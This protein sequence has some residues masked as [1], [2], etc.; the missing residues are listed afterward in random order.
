VKEVKVRP[1][2]LVKKGDVLLTLDSRQA[3]AALRV[4]QIRADS[5][6]RERRVKMEQVDKAV[7]TL[8]DYKAKAE[9]GLIPMSEYAEIL[10]A[11]RRDANS[12]E[13]AVAQAE[14]EQA[15]TALA[16]YQVVAPVDGKIKLANPNP[17]E[18]VSPQSPV[19]IL[20]ATSPAEI[21]VIPSDPPKEKRR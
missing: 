1:G 21:E 5:L 18:Y 19:I 17:G 12:T 16:Q 15:I 7:G 2:T 11:A 8:A 6:E 10:H 4:A 3:E 20:L 9:N 13:H 14:L